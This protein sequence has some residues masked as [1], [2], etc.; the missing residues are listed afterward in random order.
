MPTIIAILSKMKRFS[1][2]KKNIYPGYEVLKRKEGPD[3]FLTQP[4]T[5]LNK[6]QPSFIKATVEGLRNKT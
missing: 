4:S 2:I 1:I 5:V 3:T 6:I